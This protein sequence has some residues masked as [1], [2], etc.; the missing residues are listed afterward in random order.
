VRRLDERTNQQGQEV[1]RLFF[2]PA[3]DYCTVKLAL[4]LTPFTVAVMMVVL[5]VGT[6]STLMVKVALVSPA[7]ML[8]LFTV[9]LAT[10]SSLLDNVTRVSVVAL[11]ANTTLPVTV[12]QYDAGFGLSDNPD[13]PVFGSTVSF[14][15]KLCPL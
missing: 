11:H 15:P 12:S 2:A 4:L 9:G 3:D 10:A 8:R 1:L 13:T 7:G 5:T 14:T 6:N